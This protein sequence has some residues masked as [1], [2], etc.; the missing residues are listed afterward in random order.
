MARRTDYRALLLLPILACLAFPAAATPLVAAVASDPAGV[1]AL[2]GAG[3]AAEAGRASSRARKTQGRKALSPEDKGVLL[4]RTRFPAVVRT[5]AAMPRSGKR[6]G[7]SR[8]YQT[9]RG[10]RH[11][12][13]ERRHPA[14]A[15]TSAGGRPI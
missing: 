11:E 5:N 8:G 15:F 12:Q 1:T 13:G 14:A 7:A 2:F 10:E 6:C 9:P 4:G 3:V